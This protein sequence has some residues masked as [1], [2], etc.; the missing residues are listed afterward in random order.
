[1]F[2]G[3]SELSVSAAMR[4]IPGYYEDYTKYLQREVTGHEEIVIKEDVKEEIKDF[5]H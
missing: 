4:I 5:F 2:L 1:M 3:L